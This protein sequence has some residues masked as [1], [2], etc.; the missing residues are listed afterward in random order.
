M[1]G[2]RGGFIRCNRF[3]APFISA[4]VAPMQPGR[5]SS[6]FVCQTVL[7]KKEP[8]NSS[9]LTHLTPLTRHCYYELHRVHRRGLGSTWVTDHGHANHSLSLSHP[10]MQLN[11]SLALTHTLF[12]PRRGK[13]VFIDNQC[14]ETRLTCV[15]V[16]VY[17]YGYV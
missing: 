4:V 3:V 2:E 17:V 9:H 16:Y 7:L 14:K 5:V 8:G 13:R 6:Q 11:L 15:C 10:L 12:P 1:K